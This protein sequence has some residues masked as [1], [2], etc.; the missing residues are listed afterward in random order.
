MHNTLAYTLWFMTH[1]NNKILSDFLIQGVFY[2]ACSPPF[3]FIK[4]LFFEFLNILK[5]HIFKFLIFFILLNVKE[6]TTETIS[7][8]LFQFR[9]IFSTVNYSVDIRRIRIEIHSNDYWVILLCVLRTKS[10]WKCVYET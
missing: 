7:S 1:R 9:T 8:V 10:P 4:N 2:Q 3:F 6:C 5:D